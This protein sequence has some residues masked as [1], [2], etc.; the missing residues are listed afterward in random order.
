MTVFMSRLLFLSLAL[1]IASG[2]DLKSK[3][4]ELVS[5]TPALGNAF[6]GLQVVSLPSGR[7]LYERNPDRLFVPASNMKLFTTALA[8]ERL[9]P[10]YR[11]KTQI[12]SDTPIDA[13][14]TL[15]GDLVLVGGG[16][17]TLSGREAPHQ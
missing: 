13:D 17:P 5:K 15:V 3:I 9:G 14:G 1:S 6:I 7:V 10:Q 11:F 8:L 16:D 12:G 4:D 2:A